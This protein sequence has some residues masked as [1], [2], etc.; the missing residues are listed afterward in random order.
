ML[1]EY[2][3]TNYNPNESIF[4][5]DVNLSISNGNLYK[6]IKELCDASKKLFKRLIAEKI[7]IHVEYLK[8]S[9]YGSK[10]NMNATILKL[11]LYLIIMDVLVEPLIHILIEK[12]LI[13]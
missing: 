8:I 9:Y 2:L 5:F 4:I 13:Y 7:D 12:Y 1:Y 3:R 11:L 10:Q 6:K